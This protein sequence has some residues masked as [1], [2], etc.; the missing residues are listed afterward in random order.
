MPRDIATHHFS[1]SSTH[2]KEENE[3]LLER[4]TFLRALRDCANAVVIAA[5]VTGDA[6]LIA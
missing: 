4:T 3:R 5:A 1:L 2:T 6:V